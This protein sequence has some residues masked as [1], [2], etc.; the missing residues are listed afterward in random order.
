M[1]ASEPFN[2]LPCHRYLSA[3]CFNKTWTLLEK[4]GRTAAD[5]EQMLLLAMASLW[6]WTQRP[7]CKTRE[8]SVGYW[9]ISRVYAALG[10]V[11][12]AASYAGKCLM[13]SKDEEPF[14]LAY[15]HE[16]SARA[17]RLAGNGEAVTRHLAEARRLA[18]LVTEGDDRA[19]LEA[20]LRTIA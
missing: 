4:P 19:Q 20:D 6:H 5:D 7:D 8:L 17:A 1:D 16:G 14:Y 13:L 18:P 12:N 11:D 2:P 10:Q 15:A 3:D 9:M